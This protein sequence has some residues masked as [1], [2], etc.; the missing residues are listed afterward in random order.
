[1]SVDP[2]TWVVGMA[3][4]FVDWIV[5]RFWKRVLLCFIPLFVALAVGGLVAYGSLLNRDEL[6]DHYLKLADKEVA[7][8]ENEWAPQSQPAVDPKAASA[9]PSDSNAAST[10][11]TKDSNTDNSPETSAGPEKPKQTIPEFAELLFRRVQQLQKND[12]RSVFFVAMGY[13][14]RGAMQQG[15][16]MLNR[17]APEDRIGYLPAHAWLAEYYL[18]R[19]LTNVDELRVA[20]HHG[21][22]AMRWERI[23]PKLLAL[24]SK[25]YYQTNDLDASVRALRQAAD[26]DASFHLPLAKVAGAREKYLLV[27]EESM[28]KSLAYFKE[29]IAKEPHDFQ[30]RLLLADAYLHNKQFKEAENVLSEGLKLADSPILKTALSE[31]YR[32]VFV[33]TSQYS[34]NEWSGNI[35]LLDRAYR[36]DPNNMRIF[37][38]VARLVRISGKSPDDELMAQLQKTLASGKSTSIMHTWIAEYYLMNNDFKKAIPHLEQAV[39]RD[40]MASRCWNNLAFCLADVDAK[41]LE[42]AL[43]CAN[44][45]LQ[46]APRVPDFHDTRGTVMMK[47]NRPRDAIASFEQAIELVAQGGGAFPPQPGYHQRL[48]M[49]YE[50]AGNEAMAKTHLEMATKV[51]QQLQLAL[52]AQRKTAADKKEADKKA[53]EKAAAEKA[54]ADK[55]ASDK[56][57]SDKD[58]A[59]KDAAVKTPNQASDTSPAPGASKESDSNVTDAKATE[60]SKPADA[61]PVD[62]GVTP[63]PTPAPV[64][65]TPAPASSPSSEPVTV[66]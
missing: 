56:D 62:P 2:M 48:A 34:D 12:S 36:L 32:N 1:M 21:E 47:M 29:K 61:A 66:P 26:K 45:A 57:A 28:S 63:T 22:A 10:S 44:Q 19:P 31:V 42:E 49:A 33:A 60:P 54:A 25:H 8:W 65:A 35:E 13:V 58:A 4:C 16:N 5:T 24:I 40:P 9:K 50:S 52:E 37:E 27:A 14:Q 18:S 41:R 39:Q 38:E 3:G 53:G 51:E 7:D 15:F 55:D 23:S 17:I 20:R 6:A 30:S 11:E 46:I 59:D 43:K 64:P